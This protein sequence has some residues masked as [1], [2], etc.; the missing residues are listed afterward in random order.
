MQRL[1]RSI[2][3]WRAA[4][5]DGEEYAMKLNDKVYVLP[6]LMAYNEQTAL[7]NASLLPEAA[8]GPTRHCTGRANVVQR[9]WAHYV[10]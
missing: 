8:Q 2:V 4:L 10:V 5:S 7:F 6:L 1:L 3:Q 9:R